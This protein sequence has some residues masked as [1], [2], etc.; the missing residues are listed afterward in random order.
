MLQHA[1]SLLEPFVIVHRLL[2]VNGDLTAGR[3]REN[4]S[5][6]LDELFECVYG[7]RMHVAESLAP[8][9]PDAFQ[10]IHRFVR[11][12]RTHL[13]VQPFSTAHTGTK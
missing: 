6:N 13:P 7:E 12:P 10:V 4:A 8:H 3:I 11:L 2:T 9:G 5:A 1:G